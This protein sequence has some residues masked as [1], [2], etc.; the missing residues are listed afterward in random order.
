L[1][2]FTVLTNGKGLDKLPLIGKIVAK[3]VIKHNNK[4]MIG[5]LAKEFGISK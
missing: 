3:K 4:N 1:N 2:S 5:E